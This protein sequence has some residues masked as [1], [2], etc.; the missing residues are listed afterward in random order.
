MLQW[1]AAEEERL[2]SQNI[3]GVWRL[4]VKRIASQWPGL[5]SETTFPYGINVTLMFYVGMGSYARFIQK[6]KKNTKTNPKNHICD[7]LSL[8]SL[9]ARKQKWVYRRNTFL[10]LVTE[11]AWNRL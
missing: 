1:I 4:E 11:S 7:P 3:L 9:S 10:N 8:E 6:N 2:F 5:Q